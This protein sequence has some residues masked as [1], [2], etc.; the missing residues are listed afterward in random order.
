MLKIIPMQKSDLL[1]DKIRSGKNLSHEENLKFQFGHA[2]H[3][4]PCGI[5]KKDGCSNIIL[6]PYV[7][8]IRV[9]LNRLGPDTGWDSIGDFPQGR[10]LSKF[11]EPAW[12]PHNQLAKTILYNLKPG[13]NEADGY[14]D[15]QL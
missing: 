3:I 7:I 14:H 1:S 10:S 4:L 12:I 5:G 2:A 8:T 13:D 6:A 15:R 9:C 11:L